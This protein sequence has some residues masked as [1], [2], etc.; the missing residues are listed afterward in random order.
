M[1]DTAIRVEGLGKRY[2]I[3]VQ[4]PYNTLRETLARVVG[5]SLRGLPKV[6]SSRNGRAGNSSSPESPDGVRDSFIWALK[7]VSFEV[8]QGE[9]VGIIGRNGAGKTTLLKILARITEPTEGY[10][11]IYGRVGSLLEVGTGFHPE[12]TGREN[13]YLNGAILGMKKREIDRKF[14]E[15]VAFSEVERFVDTP[16]K[17]FSSGMY[18]RL[19]F[20]VAAHLEPE[21]LLVDE[22]LAVG[23]LGFQRKCFG[24]MGEVA[25]KGRTVIVV[26][27]N[28]GVLTRTCPTALWLEQGMVQVSGPVEDVVSSY[29]MT[30][31]AAGGE[32]LW[33]EGVANEG[34]DEFKVLGVK[35]LNGD[36]ASASIIDVRKSFSVE[37]RYR[38]NRP[39]PYCRV[40]FL[41]STLEGVP[42]FESYDAD[43]EAFAG[44][45]ELGEYVARCS[46]PAYFL[47]A[48]P[49]V[50]S[51]N[52]GIP[53]IKNLAR[54]EGVLLVHA[55]DTG[56]TGSHLHGPRQG[57]IRPR[58]HWEVTV[59]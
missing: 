36:C 32:R 56:A 23:D 33:P 41:L 42:I 51:V 13:I 6:C 38:I 57:V 55:E 19:A 40:G 18:M 52:A 8:K 58:L 45:R 2:R 10:A 22:V 54:L 14:D 5:N 9:V 43:N 11:E 27:H 48:G 12:L 47:N 28:M 39:L 20:S 50:I 15:I 21:I 24:K 59:A 3:G 35:T 30:S 49:Y 44:P 7:D 1:S 4:H 46:I 37:I 53:N 16:V 34:I 17:H 26:S 25:Q 29:L 31:S